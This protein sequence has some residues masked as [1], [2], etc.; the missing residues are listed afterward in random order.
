MIHQQLR[1]H[2]KDR[3]LLSEQE[4]VERIGATSAVQPDLRRT[5]RL[6]RQHWTLVYLLDHPEWQ[7]EGV[8]VEMH[9]R[10]CVTVLPD[11]DVETDLYLPGDQEL[12]STLTVAVQDINLAY[13][14][15]KFTRI[16]S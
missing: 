13:L 2:L 10:R 7:G 9:G 8:I 3:P 12:D 15:S 14:N 6:S 11:L 4:I 16:K 5:E 1:A